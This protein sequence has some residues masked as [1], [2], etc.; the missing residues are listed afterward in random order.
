MLDTIRNFQ[1]AV[2][3]AVLAGAIAAIGASGALA[4]VQPGKPAPDFAVQDSAGKTVKLSDFKGKTVVLEWT[5]QDCPYVRKHY[6]GN[7]MQT[8]QKEATDK[9]VVWLTISSSA[10]GQQGH[11]TGLEADE[12]TKTR[13]ASPTA[14]LL[15]PEGKVGHMYDA[16]TTPHM[17]VVDKAGVLAYMGAMD[18]KPTSNLADLKTARPYLKEAVDAVLAGDPVKVASTRAYGCSIKYATPRS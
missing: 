11:V 8:L 7:N 14:F 12:L 9:G 15:D 18:D 1:R 10:P 3:H 5:N 13:K 4:Q 16:R 17:Y 2:A 6:G